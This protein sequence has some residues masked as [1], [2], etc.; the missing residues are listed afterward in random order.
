MKLNNLLKRLNELK[1]REILEGF[2]EVIILFFGPSQSEEYP[3]RLNYS[4]I[5]TIKRYSN[6]ERYSI[7]P[8]SVN[9][10]D[11]D[12]YFNN[13]RD[14]ELADNSCRADVLNLPATILFSDRGERKWN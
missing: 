2:G 1:E 3:A 4:G 10:F 13:I 5:F 7:S 12:F 9:G 14:G 11:F 8:S 6:G